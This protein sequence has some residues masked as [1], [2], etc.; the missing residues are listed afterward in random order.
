MSTTSGGLPLMEQTQPQ[1]YLTYNELAWALNVLQTGVISRTETAPPV[2]PSVG[3]AYI[4]AGPA[5]AEWAGLEDKVLFWFGGVWN[6]LEPDIVQGRGIYVQDEDINIRW[7]PLGSPPGYVNAA[8]SAGIELKGLLYTSN[9]GSTADSDPGAGLFKWDNATQAS[10]T[11]LYFD[12]STLDSVSLATF[13]AGLPTTGYLY[14]QQFDDPTKW[15][16]WKWSAI[17][18]GTGYRKFAVSLQ[19]IGGSIAD[20]KTVYCDF[21]PAGNSGG[22]KYTRG[23]AWSNGGAA[24]DAAEANVVYV[25]CHTAGTITRA[26]VLTEGGSG[27]AQIDVWNDTFANYP[28]TDADSITAAAPLVLTSVTKLEETTFTGWDTVVA[29]GDILAFKLDS[30]STFTFLQVELEITP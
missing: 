1:R 18:D 15:Q 27:S 19:G 17:T 4:P 5:T 12:D 25:N 7:N 8:G 23:A 14:L 30:S 2:S 9:T 24:L 16:L 3:D 11:E 22:G 10:A 6:V 29:A 21:K 20:D 26:R 13:F 28:P